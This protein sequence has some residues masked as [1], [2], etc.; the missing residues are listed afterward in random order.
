MGLLHFV[1]FPATI[2]EMILPNIAEISEISKQHAEKERDHHSAKLL[3]KSLRILFLGISSIT[4]VNATSLP[5]NETTLSKLLSHQEGKPR[6]VT[7]GSDQDTDSRK[8]P[9]QLVDLVSSRNKNGDPETERS[10][11]SL[12]LTP[13]HM[14]DLLDHMMKHNEDI[15]EMIQKWQKEIQQ[16]PSPTTLELTFR[17]SD[18]DAY[19]VRIDTQGISYSTQDKVQTRFVVYRTIKNSEFESA[20]QAGLSEVQANWSG[21]SRVTFSPETADELNESRKSDLNPYYHEV[22]QFSAEKP[23]IVKIDLDYEG[24]EAGSPYQEHYIS[25]SQNPQKPFPGTDFAPPLFA[26]IDIAPSETGDGV[27]L[28]MSGLIENAAAHTHTLKPSG[29]ATQEIQQAAENSYFNIF[30][31]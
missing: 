9:I 16:L 31:Q 10:T 11:E 4:F 6:I 30:G 15:P 24:N 23:S 7:E 22:D 2:K 25:F 29:K 20:T 27:T 12:R 14:P 28:E 21:E 8:A 1:Y 5:K 18:E 3:Q 13:I 19:K 17:T 26:R